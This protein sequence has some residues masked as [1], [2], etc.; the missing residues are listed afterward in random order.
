MSLREVAVRDAHSLFALISSDPKVQQYISPPPPSENAFAGFIAWSHQERA[1][2]R[3]VCFAVVPRGLRRAVGL[4]QLRALA[5]DFFIA[6]W[7]FALGSAFWSTGIFSEAAH[8]VAD[9]AFDVLGAHRIEGRAATANARGNGALLKI[10]ATSEAVLKD[11]LEREGAYHEQ[12]LWTIIR[13]E[14]KERPSVERERFSADDVQQRIRQAI[15][16]CQAQ[17]IATAPLR[18]SMRVRPFPFFIG[19][20]R[21]H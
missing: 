3:S 11:A 17:L 2:G 1:A 5:L 7:G 21:I 14:W 16:R 4:F 9:F 12:L 15:E 8:L 18:S 13:E 10:G 20:S 19:G 6:E